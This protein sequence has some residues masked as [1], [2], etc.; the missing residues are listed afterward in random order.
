MA[1]ASQAI[2]SSGEVVRGQVFDIGPRYKDPSYI[3]EGAYGMVW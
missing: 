2:R 1:N 3:G